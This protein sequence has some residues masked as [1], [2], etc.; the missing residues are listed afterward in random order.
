MMAEDTVETT[1]VE[2]TIETLKD[3]ISE[4]EDM[5]TDAVSDED[6]E[7]L[8]ELEKTLKAAENTIEDARKDVIEPELDVRITVDETVNGLRRTSRTYYYMRDE[9]GIVDVLESAGVDRSE[10]TEVNRKAAQN[11]ADENSVDIGEF[12]AGNET[13]YYRRT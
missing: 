5:D 3:G 12:I 10:F 6:T 8:T 2:E 13:T 4:L 7:V 1:D 11:A 9:D